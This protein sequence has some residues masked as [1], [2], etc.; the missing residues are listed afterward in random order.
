[1]V[2]PIRVPHRVLT[3]SE[4][5]SRARG[6][7]PGG[8]AWVDP[9]IAEMG[10]GQRSSPLSDPPNTPSSHRSF[11][12]QQSHH[13]RSPFQA[14]SSP[15]AQT[16]SKPARQSTRIKNKSS[17]KEEAD[18]TPSK[19]PKELARGA[20]RRQPCEACIKR[21]LDGKGSGNC[22][23]RAEGSS[24]RC[25]A[26]TSHVCKPISRELYSEAM[27]LLGKNVCNL[28]TVTLLYTHY[29]SVLSISRGAQSASQAHSRRRS[30]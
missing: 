13:S 18:Q 25:S 29:L 12:S 27:P 22:Y 3:K 17:N 30:R 24:S 23:D 5:E 20:Q 14:A 1:M 8:T 10:S 15:V 7:T 21:A 2:P 6:S 19:A 11:H 28:I 4:E 16:P 26:C 9:R